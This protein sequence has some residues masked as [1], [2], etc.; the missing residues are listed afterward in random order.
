MG[1]LNHQLALYIFHAIHVLEKH[2]ICVH[3]SVN[4]SGVKVSLNNCKSNFDQ[5][6]PWWRVD[7]AGRPMIWIWGPCKISFLSFVFCSEFVSG[8]TFLQEHQGIL[9]FWEAHTYSQERCIYRLKQFHALVWHCVPYKLPLVSQLVIFHLKAFGVVIGYEHSDTL[10]PKMDNR[11]N[12]VP[13]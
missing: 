10:T 8:S 4:E 3:F 12:T 9:I 13:K 11:R 5:F 6:W 1:W 2:L 7:R